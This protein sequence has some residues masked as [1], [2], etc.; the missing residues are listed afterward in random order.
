MSVCLLCACLYGI[1]VPV[2][3][4]HKIDISTFTIVMLVIL[5]EWPHAT[6]LTKILP[7]GWLAGYERVGHSFDTRLLS[8]A[9]PPAPHV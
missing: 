2:D 6:E 9:I 1:C 7:S 8:H 4:K 5:K 3:C